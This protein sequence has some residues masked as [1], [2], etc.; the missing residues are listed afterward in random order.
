[1]KSFL[2]I[3]KLLYPRN[4]DFKSQKECWGREKALPRNKSLSIAI[5]GPKAMLD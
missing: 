3:E 5:L 4:K 1:M 2:I